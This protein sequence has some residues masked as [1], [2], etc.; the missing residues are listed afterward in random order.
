MVTRFPGRPGRASGRVC[1]TPA[2]SVRRGS[3]GYP[4][5]SLALA[6]EISKPAT[7][8]VTVTRSVPTQAPQR[9]APPSPSRSSSAKINQYAG[10]RTCARTR[11]SAKPHRARGAGRNL[12]RGGVGGRRGVS[13][14]RA[15][16]GLLALT[17]A[18]M[19]ARIAG[20]RSDHAATIAASSGSVGLAGWAGVAGVDVGG[21]VGEPKPA[22]MLPDLLP[23]ESPIPGF[24]E[25]IRDSSDP[26]GVIAAP[27]T[28]LH[29]V[30]GSRVFGMLS[31]PV[32]WPILAS[33]LGSFPAI[34]V[35]FAFV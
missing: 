17:I 18:A 32:S 2:R 33:W 19:P 13:P 8:C 11:L 23:P 27:R 3:A 34:Y 9:S 1:P 25:G 16:R 21:G 14:G 31:D 30:A 6:P 26:H 28:A 5:R 10:S 4:G 35:D 12:P 7:V 24:P 22:R 29:V 15:Q 20:G